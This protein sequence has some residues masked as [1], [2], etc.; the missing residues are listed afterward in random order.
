MYKDIRLHG[1][2]GDQIEYFVMVAGTQDYQRYF[3]NIVQDEYN[4]R[5][6]TAGNEIKLS[7]EGI[8]HHGN[9][10]YFCEYMFGMEQPSS[11]LFKPKIVNRLVMYGARSDRDTGIVS[12]SDHTS[13]H[14]TYDSIFSDGNAVSNYLFF[15]YSSKMTSS[16]LKTQQEDLVK[17]IGKEL[18]RSDSIGQGQDD[19]LV[20]EL[21]PLLKD[22]TSQLFIIK[23]I[24][25]KH[26]EYRDLFHQLYFNS[27]NIADDDFDRL[28]QLGA[29]N[30]IDP[31]QQERM[32]IDVMYRHPANK[33]VVDEYRNILLACNKDGEISTLHNARLTRLKTLSVRN[34][35]PGA[36]FYTLD[37]NLNKDCNLASRAEQV[38][39][40]TTREVLE[41]IFLREKDIESQ[42]N[43]EDMLKL[44]KAKKCALENSD[45][46]FDQLMIDASKEC[47]EKIRDGADSA[48]LDDLSY[49]TGY[50]DRFNDV[51]NLVSH[52]AFMQHGRITEEMLQSVLE[53]K[54]AFDKLKPGCFQELFIRE[55]FEN[56]Y[57]GRFGRRKL[58]S[59][60]DGLTGIEAG[61]SSIQDLHRT[62]NQ[63]RQ[64]EYIFLVLLEHIPD[65]IRKFYAKFDTK[66]IEDA[67]RRE[68]TEELKTKKRIYTDIPDH[69]FTETILTI[70]KEVVYLSTLLPAI[71]SECNLTLREDFLENSGLDRF[72]VEE[73]ERIY[74]EG[75]GLDL[76]D[77]YQIR[78]G[79]N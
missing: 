52:L 53:H 48:L 29:T 15:V 26:R 40:A 23:L 47:D 34:K 39:L 58:V 46:S 20:S 8:T 4:L 2:M 12:F 17:R 69:L 21:F 78:K 14:E 73:L 38:Y 54:T 27:K 32:R 55:L 72:Y 67:L 24:N 66:E 65:R 10:G 57:L 22:E 28:V 30:K 59:L 62:L 61:T 75:N 11:D 16:Q 35:I 7:P 31:Y 71:V 5:I 70:K 33:R 79:L 36:L 74:F 44:I 51:A 43:R 25:H 50:L 13:G 42:I 76:E 1:Y 9:G 19:A 3:F 37:E 41:G 77:L 18:K 68:F 49:V 45:N 60:M 6:F 56:V 63:I 64:E